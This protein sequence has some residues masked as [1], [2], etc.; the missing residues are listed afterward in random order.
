MKIR[1][2]HDNKKLDVSITRKDNTSTNAESLLNIDQLSFRYYAF[3]CE[4]N[5]YFRLEVQQFLMSQY[6]NCSL[7][8][9][10][11]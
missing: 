3:N 5:V 9:T 8:V 4:K 10:S 2:L 6:V 1:K 11:Y 7:N